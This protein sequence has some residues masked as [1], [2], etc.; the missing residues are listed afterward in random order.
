MINIKDLKKDQYKITPAS[1]T[2]S[3]K[4]IRDITG[5]YKTLDPRDGIMEFN[6]LQDE[7]NTTNRF[8]NFPKNFETEEDE[9]DGILKSIIKDPVKTLIVKPG[10]RIAQAGLEAY[11]SLADDDRFKDVSLQDTKINIPGLGEFNI[12]GQRKGF[13]GVKQIAGDVAK[14]GSYLLTPAGAQ[15]TLA[16]QTTKQAIIQGAKSGAI[17]GSLL[18]GGESAIEN[19]T[20]GD[21]TK[22]I[23]KGGVAG[24]V[25]GG[26][27]GGVTSRITNRKSIK[28]IKEDDFVNDL[29][30]PKPTEAVKQASLL[31][32][33]VSEPGFL[34][35]SKILPSKRDKQLA[36]VAKEYV[37]M[38]NPITKNIA[39]IDNGIKQINEGVKEYVKVNKIP[40]NTSQLKTQLNKGKNELNLIFASDS[41]AEKT[42]N[43]VVKEFMRD[44]KKLDT[45]GLLARRQGFDKIPAIK[46]LL[47]S[48]GLGENTR[49]EI[50]LTVRDMANKYIAKLLP[51]DNLYKNKLLT[52][53][54]LIEAL[55][56][57]A[58][59]NTAMIGK[60][61]LQMLTKE[62]PILKWI[63]GG[64]AG[65]ASVG[66]GGAII[67]STN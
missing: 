29:V 1:S 5:S 40:F 64:M 56:N 62:Y 21:I 23:L 22:D 44:I 35:K 31:Q 42:Y 17:S 60:N 53:S 52:E 36:E 46:K 57:M 59:K 67:G 20:I 41:N 15:S 66:V 12:E 4:N 58:E 24:S 33:R 6:K 25:I 16:K 39:S 7:K 18:S 38:N 10:T 8:G 19:N 45:E 49:K 37:S 26:A 27:L 13:E 47:D 50:V 55:G 2:G 9:K 34:Q 63:V 11:G 32:K 51:K 61:K 14:A 54:K 48:Q 65:A 30:S 43:A 28:A 3:I